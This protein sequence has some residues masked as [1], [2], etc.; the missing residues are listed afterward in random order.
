MKISLVC[1]LV[2]GNESGESR[3]LSEPKKDL[4]LSWFRFF[5]FLQFI[6]Y[7]LIFSF[8]LNYFIFFSF[9]NLP[10]ATFNVIFFICFSDFW[11]E[12]IFSFIRRLKG[13]AKINPPRM[14]GCKFFV[15]YFHAEKHETMKFPST[16][17]KPF[18]R[19]KLRKSWKRIVHSRIKI[20][21]LLSLTVKSIAIWLQDV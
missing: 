21:F 15:L 9:F 4:V 6:K 12:D 17:C 18:E 3:E 13:I 11:S 19:M 10:T 8:I 7:Y 16:N 14:I 5:S 20:H 2:C 1:R